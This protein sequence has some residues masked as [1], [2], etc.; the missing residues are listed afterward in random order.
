MPVHAQLANGSIAPNFTV[1]DINGNTWTLYDLLDEGKTVYLDFFATWCGPCWSYH[2]TH[3]L[4]DLWE[5][6]GPPG[7]DEAFVFSI[8]GDA[9]TNNACLYGP[10]GC[11][12]GT[13]GNWVDGTPYPIV[14]S[15]TVRAQYAVAFYPTIYMICP[16]NKKIYVVGQLNKNGLWNQRNNLCPAPIVEINVNNVKNVKCYNTST[17]SIDITP[18]GGTPPYTY[19]WSNGASTQDLNNIPAGSYTCTVTASNGW[20]GVTD[21]IDVLE[22]SE[23]LAVNIVEQTPMGCNGI[24]AS[25]TVEAVGGWSNS[26]TYKWSHGPSGEVVAGLSPGNYTVSVTDAGAC[27]VTKVINVAPAVYPTASIVQPGVLTCLQPSME[28]DGTNSSQGNEFSYQWFANGGGNIVSGNNTL[29]PVVNAPGNYVLQ[30]T[31]TENNCISYAT[32]IVTANIVLPNA[33]AGPA[34]VVSCIQPSIVLQGSGSI[35]ANFTYLWTASNGGNIVS[36]GN[37]LSPTVNAGGTYTLQVTNTTTGCTKT[38]TTSVSGNNVAPTI[39]TTNGVLTCNIDTVTL[40]TTTNSNHPA[41][42]WTGP[43]G[44]TASVQN[45]AVTVSG[46]YNLVL[47]DTVTGCTSTA[48]ANVTTNFNA[49]G[50]AATG[51]ALTC[52]VNNVTLSGSSPDTTATFAWTGPNG[53]TSQMQNPNVNTAGQYVLVTTNPL[54][55]CTSSANATVALNNAPPV[56]VAAT[57]GNLNCNTNQIQLNGAGSSQGANFTYQWSTANG[58]II[59]GGNTLTPLVDAVGSYVLQVNNSNNG[60]TSTASV[61]VAQSPAV[62]AAIGAQNNVSCHGGANGTAT[63]TP[64]GGNGTYNYA[65]S[66]GAN[67][68]A[69][70]NLSAGTYL[71]TITDGENCTAS[72]SV[73]ISQ[74]APLAANA[75]ATAQTANG[76]NDGTATANPNGGVANYTYAW[77]NNETT[78]TITGLAPGSY[79]VTVTDANGCTSVQTVTVNSFNCTLSASISGVNVSCFGANNGAASVSLA[80]AAEPVTYSWNNG[81]NTASVSGLAPGQYTVSVVDDNNCPASLSINITEPTL[82]AANATATNESAAGANDGSAT[83]NPTGGTAPYTYLWSNAA[84]TQTITGLAPGI[85]SV[86]ITDDNDCTVEQTVVVNS[87]NC[88]ISAEPAISNVTCAGANNGSVTLNLNGGTAPFTYLWNNGATTSTISNLSGGIY[89]ASVTDAND[90]QIVATAVVSEPMPYSNWSVETVS[91][92]CANDPTGSA[93]ATITGGTAPYDFLWSNGQNSNVATNLTAGNYSVTVTDQNGCQSSTSVQITAVDNVPPAVSVQNATVFIN[94]SGLAEVN[95]SALAAQIADNC[96]V[97]S[98]V[99]SPNIFNCGQLGQQEVTVTVTDLSGLTATATAVVTVV[100]DIDPVVTCPA[101][102]TRCA[103]DN[104]VNYD[105]PVAVDNCLGNGGQ[106]KLENGLESGSVFPIGSTTQTYSYTDAGGNIGACSFSVTVVD[107]VELDNVA[108]TNDADGQGIGAID[109]TVSGG[110]MPYT[111]KW[112]KEGQIVGETEDL[113]NLGEGHYTVIITDANGCIVSKEDIYVG[114]LVGTSEPSWLQGVRLQPN[115]TNGITQVIFSQF[116]AS[117]LEVSVIDATGRVLLTEISDNPA[118]VT[119][120]CSN[121][122][123]GLYL[124]RFRT[125]A[126][127][128]VRKLMVSR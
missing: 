59:S 96:G 27:T 26:Y 8:E 13:Q 110:T 104:V 121:L 65:W 29:T 49:P 23:P 122:P 67:T 93:T 20:M 28:L 94:A 71:V 114:N 2:N 38:S 42:A 55:G 109:I 31:N 64:G 32:G 4:K 111:F 63:V 98:S 5:E 56:A 97:A 124:V 45:P 14:E 60:C 90:C 102:I 16:A 58:N 76:V 12:G 117:Q 52:V 24:L 51:G 10:A 25:A 57:P 80:G 62:T 17:G 69:I 101:N 85:Y 107:E 86:T 120:D 87:F 68:A 81:A 113:N 89:T 34:G 100:D 108:V 48:T 53:F 41:F 9:N 83:A 50:A 105:A 127:V 126:E 21:P 78:Q 47:T 7:T 18:S 125:G 44:Y 115:P 84:T 119:L 99:V 123:E 92:A 73:S 116:I 70:T 66:N 37:T 54:N 74:P 11:V 15:S 3:A 118:V 6:Y 46:A 95:L 106:W 112:T 75:S 77:S 30:V 36:G 88:A 128:G 61:N 91:P 40:T 43:N 35:G 1:T 103:S 82:L 72:T 39:S 19:V 22:P 33:D 79:T